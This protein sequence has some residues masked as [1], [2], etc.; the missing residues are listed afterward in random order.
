MKTETL[1]LLLACVL[2]AFGL[3]VAYIRAVRGRMDLLWLSFTAL[4]PD[5]GRAGHSRSR[6]RE[7]CGRSGS[8]KA[9]LQLFYD[10][11][12]SL[13]SVPLESSPGATTGQ[14]VL[15]GLDS[16]DSLFTLALVVNF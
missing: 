3:L 14:N 8:W 5:G 15:T 1:L 13:I 12:P 6:R 2:V 10:N 16:L 7:S 9:S 11:R 4:T